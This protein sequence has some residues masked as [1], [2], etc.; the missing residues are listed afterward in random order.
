[1]DDLLSPAETAETLA[2]LRVFLSEGRFPAPEGPFDM[3]WPL[4]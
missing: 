1:L 4:V 2:R 3:P